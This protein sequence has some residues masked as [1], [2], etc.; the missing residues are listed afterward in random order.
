MNIFKRNTAKRCS[1]KTLQRPGAFSASALQRFN[2]STP[3]RA[4]TLIE[5]ILVL[6][7]LVIIT[8]L[9]APAMADS[10]VDGRW[11]PRRGGWWR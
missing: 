3:C 9:A 4:F 6:A 10:S 8:S 11:T 7:L 1:V 5:L 2:A